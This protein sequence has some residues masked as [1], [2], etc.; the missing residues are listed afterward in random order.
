MGQKDF[1]QLRGKAIS[2]HSQGLP[3]F[4]VQKNM[5]AGLFASR[6]SVVHLQHC[7]LVHA[8]QC[9]MTIHQY[10]SAQSYCKHHNFTSQTFNARQ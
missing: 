1:N 6:Q 3:P 2:L 5:H 7:C 4:I 10:I 8:M 9:L